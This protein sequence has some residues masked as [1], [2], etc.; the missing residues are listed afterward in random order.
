M[1]PSAEPCCGLGEEAAFLLFI[2]HH[3]SQ[4]LLTSQIEQTIFYV[5]LHA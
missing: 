2:Q 1:F 3:I 5:F 4:R